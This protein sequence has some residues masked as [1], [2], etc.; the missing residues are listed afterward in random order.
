MTT[1]RS[2]MRRVASAT[3]PGSSA[4]SANGFAVATAQKPQ[5]RVQRSPAIMNVAVPLLQH[6][7]WLGHLALSQTVWSFS[8]SSRLRVWAKA[9]VVGSLVRSHSGRR[10][11]ALTW[12]CVGLDSTILA[13]QSFPKSGQLVRAEIRQDLSIHLDHRRQFLS[14]KPHHLRVC[15]IVLDDIEGF[16]FDPMRIEPMLGFVT[17]AAIRFDKQADFC[18]IHSLIC[19]TAV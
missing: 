6:S 19:K 14:G 5:A 9:S 11:R 10:G 15:G 18:R 1:C 13:L 4:S 7:Q 16:V 3:R 17:P 2:R 12:A 8:S